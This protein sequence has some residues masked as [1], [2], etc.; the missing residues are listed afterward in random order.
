[1]DEYINHRHHRHTHLL[2]LLFGK[3]II[4]GMIMHRTAVILSNTYH[5]YGYREQV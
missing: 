1:M 5:P 2:L 4:D 3:I